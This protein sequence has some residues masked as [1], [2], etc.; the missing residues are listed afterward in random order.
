[1]QSLEIRTRLEHCQRLLGT[2]AVPPEL[3]GLAADLIDHLIQLHDARRLTPAFLQLSMRA[4]EGIEALERVV[5]P[6]AEIAG[7]QA[8]AEGHKELTER[9]GLPWVVSR[10]DPL[11]A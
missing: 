4:F 2:I 9:S 11:D 7:A 8:E 10:Y 3:D 6:L 5:A 1:M